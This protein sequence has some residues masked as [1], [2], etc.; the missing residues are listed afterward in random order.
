MKRIAIIIGLWLA[1]SASVHGQEPVTYIDRKT[2]KEAT[3]S[4]VIQSETAAGITIKQG[5]MT[6]LIPA[7]D[8][9]L[10]LYKVANIKDVEYKTPFYKE[11]S[12]LDPKKM[13]KERREFLADAQKDFD[14]LLPKVRDNPNAFRYVQYRGALVQVHIAREEP[15]KRDAAV[16]ALEKFSTEHSAGWEIV[17]CLKQLA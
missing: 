14:A 17:P 10:V 6:K 12:G 16:A 2:G 3:F 1:W 15:A 7:M 11:Q 4:G 9:T 8:I 5:T 13:P